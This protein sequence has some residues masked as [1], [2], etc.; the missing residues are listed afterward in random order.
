MDTEDAARSWRTDQPQRHGE[1]TGPYPRSLGSCAC[2]DLVWFVCLFC[3]IYFPLFFL[4]FSSLP[5][6]FKPTTRVYCSWRWRA[7]ISVKP[8]HGRYKGGEL[9]V[10]CRVLCC[11]VLA[12]LG[13][14]LPSPS[15]SLRLEPRRPCIGLPM[16]EDS[17]SRCCLIA[18][19]FCRSMLH[20]RRLRNA[21]S[22]D[23]LSLCLSLRGGR[24][25]GS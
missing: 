16:W 21:H 18:E 12:W 14:E 1:Q 7:L 24:D 20:Y 15:G 23:P 17:C 11:V 8:A 4:R 10:L 22:L 19:L 9:R 13:L 6:L 25:D 2:S 5:F 3:S